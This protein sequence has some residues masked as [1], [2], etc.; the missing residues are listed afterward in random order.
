M[1]VF[2]PKYGIEGPVY[3]TKKDSKTSQGST[4]SKAETSAPGSAASVATTAAASSNG[5]THTPAQPQAQS[6]GTKQSEEFVLD[7]EKQTIVSQEGGRSYT[8]FDKAAVRI[9]VEETFGHRRHLQLTLV[10]RSELPAS[11]QM[12]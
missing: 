10:D 8:V 11:E 2:V 5:Q 4:G 7:E 9:T 12:S 1:I 3:L 6:Q